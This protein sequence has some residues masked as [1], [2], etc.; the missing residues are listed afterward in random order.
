M[1]QDHTARCARHSEKSGLSCL[2]WICT[3]TMVSTGEFTNQLRDEFT[4]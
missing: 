4:Q 2:K 3:N 1:Y